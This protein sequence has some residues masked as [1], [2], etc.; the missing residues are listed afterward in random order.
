MSESIWNRL[1]PGDL[2]RVY[3]REQKARRVGGN[4][5]ENSGVSG[6]VD[7]MMEALRVSTGGLHRTQSH[8]TCRMFLTWKNELKCRAILNARK[9]NEGDP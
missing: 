5:S 9:V 1:V 6:P 4:S 7:S 2:L 8:P 3:K